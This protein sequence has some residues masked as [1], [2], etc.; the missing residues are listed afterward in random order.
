MVRI[1]II[2]I[3]F[4]LTACGGGGDTSES[5]SATPGERAGGVPAEGELARSRAENRCDWPE[6]GAEFASVD[7]QALNLDPAAVQSAVRYANASN[8]QSVRIYRY[9][10]LAGEGALDSLTKSIPNNVWSTTKGVVSVLTG[11]AV[12]LGFLDLDDP[13]GLYIPEADA[14]HGALT[15]RQMLTQTSGMPLVW[16][17]DLNV[18][19]VNTVR[20][21]LALPIE[22]EPGTKFTYGQLTVTLLAHAVERAVGMD[23]QEFAQREVFDPIGIARESWFWLR[24]R[25]GNTHGYAHLFMA[26][27]ELARVGHLMLNGGTWDGQRLLPEDYVRQAGSPSSTNG[28]YGYLLWS[29]AGDEGWTVEMPG[30]R[31]LKRPLIASAPRD[32]YAFVG[33]LDQIIFVI[34]SLDMVVVRTGLPGNYELDTQTLITAHPGRWMH[35]FF[36]ILMAGV[37]DQD[38]ADP[39]PYSSDIYVQLDIEYF[40]RPELIL[41][42]L[43]LGPSAPEGCNLLGC[44]GGISYE[45]WVQTVDDALETLLGIGS[46]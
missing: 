25:T 44:D 29:N 28:F 30:S 7:P 37:L 45:G 41:G 3:L 38:I 27:R 8:A 11:R 21:A 16:A 32:L 23:I 43:A 10:C 46:P 36:R 22:H 26:P 39:G 17:S 33:F 13:I 42:S 31:Y 5:S 14:E 40:A 18:A 34:P 20:E 15:F 12:Q 35:E 6:A 2:A 4:I 24:D 9:G 19:S 1:G